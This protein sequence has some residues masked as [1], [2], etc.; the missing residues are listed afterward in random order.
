MTPKDTATLLLLSI[1]LDDLINGRQ[2]T[3]D[4]L[5]ELQELAPMLDSILDRHED[6]LA[7]STYH[8]RNARA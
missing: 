3:P 7:P 5:E 2:L 6:A 8:S 1:A 4:I